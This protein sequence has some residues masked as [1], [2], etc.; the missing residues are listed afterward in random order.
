[1][2]LEFI[3]VRV[4][5][6]TDE[7]EEAFALVYREYLRKGYTDKNS[8]GLRLS[9]HNALP[10]A[11]TFIA[12]SEKNVIIATATIVPDSFLG[13]PMDSIYYD[14]LN[15]LRRIGARLK[16]GDSALF[17]Y[18]LEFIHLRLKVTIIF[19]LAGYL[20]NSYFRP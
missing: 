5:R 18:R 14:E 20:K 16:K 4:A 11:T 17:Q 9:L 1:M 7:L 10:D 3:E 8:S 12:L 15:R 13:L 19:S 6:D 2:P